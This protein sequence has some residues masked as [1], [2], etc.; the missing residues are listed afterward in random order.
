[1]DETALRQARFY[2]PAKKCGLVLLVGFAYYLFVLLTG[3]RIPCIFSLLTGIYCPGCGITR[4]FMA[5]GQLDFAL[6][7]RNN[8]LVMV[9]APFALVFA[10]RRW[11]LYI[12]TGKTDPDRPEQIFLIFAAL[13]TAVFWILRN[14]P[15]FFWLMPI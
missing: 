3:W 15:E 14:R 10:L 2:G 8:A 13:L 1:M 4:M 7:F 12:K 11:A 5:L 9:L 6:A